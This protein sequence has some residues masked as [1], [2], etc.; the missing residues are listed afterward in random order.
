MNTK[1][2]SILILGITTLIIFSSCEIETGG[3]DWS[4]F[5]GKWEDGADVVWT[6]KSSGECEISESPITLSWEL[7]TLP[8]TVRIW[9]IFNV[10]DVKMAYTLITDNKIELEVLDA[11][12]VA[13]VNDLGVG[14]TIII[15]RK[16]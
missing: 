7:D 13:R 10:F 5:I 3:A 2:L 12:L 14:D 9:S 6:F 11:S 16:I 8:D 15:Q 4:T 1:G